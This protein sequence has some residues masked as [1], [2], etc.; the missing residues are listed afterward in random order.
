MP[1]SRSGSNF[2][3]PPDIAGQTQGTAEVNAQALGE[4]GAQ[5]LETV[6]K[7]LRIWSQGPDNTKLQTLTKLPSNL[8]NLKSQGRALNERLIAQLIK[9]SD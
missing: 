4:T 5:S 2:T 7:F 9:R 3:P 8:K 6:R 1:I